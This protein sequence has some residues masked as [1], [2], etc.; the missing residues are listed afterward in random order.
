MLQGARD[1]RPAAAPS[2][3]WTRAATCGSARAARRPSPG[4]PVTGRAAPSRPT[5]TPTWSSASS[6]ERPP[7]RPQEADVE[8][9]RQAIR[10]HIAEPLGLSR[11]GRRR[12][13]LRDPERPDRRTWCARPS[14]RRAM[15]RGTSSL[16]AFGGAGPVHCAALR[17]RSGVREVV[18][19]LGRRRPR[20]PPTVWPRR[21]SS[22]PRSCPI[23]RR[24][25]W[26]PRGV[27]KNFA[28][29][30]GRS[31]RRSTVRGSLQARSSLCR[32]VDMRYSMQLA[33]LATPVPDGPIDAAESTAAAAPSS[34][35]TPTCS[36]P[37]PGSARPGSRPS[38]TGYARPVC[39]RSPGLP[40]LAGQAAGRPAA[41]ASA[42]AR[43]AWTPRR[44][45][46]HAIYDYASCG[47]AT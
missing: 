7:R 33:E 10:T 20:S 34:S 41:P 26:T 36:A 24:S 29:S 38:P 28:S 27:E 13:D 1:R 30:R 25:R 14:S 47:P 19:P 8:R 17:G 23:R 37:V 35:G 6:P 12:R 42:T 40:E 22:W 44:L 5:P 15:I 31:A 3:G 45:R 43:S 2:P 46:R 11:R 39:C 9:P 21:T 32:E 18:V 16:Y 4:P